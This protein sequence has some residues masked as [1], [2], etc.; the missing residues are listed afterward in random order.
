MCGLDCTTL[1]SFPWK[2][3]WMPGTPLG[4]SKIQAGG[5]A[6]GL[7]E[8]SPE[9]DEAE[10][11]GC[12][13]SCQINQGPPWRPRPFISCEGLHSGEGYFPDSLDC[14]GSKSL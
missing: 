11:L 4:D 7:P 1:G 3:F 9:L 12:R 5:A 14:Q 6:R 10:V 8:G 2:Q 13:G